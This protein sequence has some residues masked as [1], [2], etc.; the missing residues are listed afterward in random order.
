LR[1]WLQEKLGVGGAVVVCVVAV[2]LV[3]YL[4]FFREASPV[5]SAN[6]RVFICA[7]TGLT[8]NHTIK[9]G[10]K[11]PVYSPHSGKNTGFPAEACHWT[12][13]GGVKLEPTYVLLNEY[14]GKEGP[15]ICPDCGRKVRRL[16]PMPP[17][18]KFAELE[19]AEGDRK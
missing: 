13:D 2:G 14:I 11:N 5:A 8:F 10:E 19:Q 15:T 7:E 18:S 16:N 4:V 12:R 9:D 17:L 6:D 3:V 1:E